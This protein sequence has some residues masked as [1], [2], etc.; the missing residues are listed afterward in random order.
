[1]S[2]DSKRRSEIELEATAAPARA[3]V[4]RTAP[5]ALWLRVRSILLRPEFSLPLITLALAIYLSFASQYFL[6]EKNLLNVTEGV[7]I[8]GIAAAFATIVVISGGID[9]TPVVVF[10]ISGLAI[11]WSLNH[12]VP[13]VPAIVIGI[14]AGGAIGLING[15]LIA[16][17]NLDPFIVTLGTNFVFAGLG[18]VV[19]DGN[20]VIFDNTNFTSIG[21][22]DLIGSIPT[23]TVAMVAA[24]AL[25]FC[26]LRFTGFGVY[27]FALGGDES[28]A[29]LSGVPVKR[30]KI[31]VYVVA[32]LGAGA[33][34]ALLASS[35]GTAAPFYATGQTDL[36]TILAAVI[37]GGTALS[38]GRGSVIG[39][40]VGILLLGII[41]NGLV[42]LNISTFWQP[43]I[44][45]VLLLT[46]IVLDE[47]RRRTA[48]KVVT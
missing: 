23:V 41:A 6:T 21:N 40:L 48:L 24:F 39:T 36:L 8:L 2:M 27:I 34:G 7:A 11:F 28:A 14:L 38:G 13:L 37:I 47:V 1:M 16:F 31:L 45:G 30:A 15:L 46:A 17:G 32:G 20:P 19:T 35:S 29:R 10:V 22:G 3:A 9:L 4:E 12:G 44:V 42:L 26:I 43:V 18:F 25:T 5:R 33:A